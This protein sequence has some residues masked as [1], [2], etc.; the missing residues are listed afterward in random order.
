M[1]ITIESPPPDAV[2]KFF[3]SETPETEIHAKSAGSIDPL[4]CVVPVELAERL[5]CERNKATAEA[6]R[7]REEIRL[8][9]MENLGLADGDV[10]TLKRLKD[11]INFE[12]PPEP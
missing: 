2:Q 7:L 10:C 11:A 6:A 4:E 9:I 12:L 1:N 8:T 5:E 3:S